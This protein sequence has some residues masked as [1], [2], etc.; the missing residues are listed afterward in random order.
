MENAPYLF[1]AFA[2]I[3]ALVFAYVLMLIRN[4]RKLRREI[5]YLKEMLKG[6]AEGSE[7]L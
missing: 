2:V 5:A 6:S 1:A 7:N 3:W 4:Q